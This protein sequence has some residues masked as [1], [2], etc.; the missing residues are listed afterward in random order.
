MPINKQLYDVLSDLSKLAQEDEVLRNKAL[1]D[2]LKADP[3]KPDEFR[4]AI[5][6]NE[7]FWKKYPVPNFGHLMTHETELTGL[8]GFRQQTPIPGYFTSDKFLDSQDTIHSFQKMH[9][10]AAEQRVKLGLVKSDVDTL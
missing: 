9:Q 4:K 6:D 8:I 3:S 1:D 2:I 10:L 7:D 5:K